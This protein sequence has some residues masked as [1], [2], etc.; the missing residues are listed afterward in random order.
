MPAPFKIISRKLNVIAAAVN[1]AGAFLVFLYFQIID[2][3]P[4]GQQAVR[5]PDIGS[6][7]FFALVMAG[8]FTL[9]GFLVDKNF[10][11][12]EEWYTRLRE[13][14]SPAESPSEIQR[15]V[16]NYS[17]T[18]AFMTFLMWN[19]AGIT[20][21]ILNLFSGEGSAAYAIRFFGG[22]VGVG[23][24]LTTPIHYFIIDQVWRD[25]IAV[26]FPQGELS[27]IKS[28]R[29]PVLGRLLIVFL[30]IGLWPLGLMA[31]LS[32][33]R[34]QLLVTSA[35][36]QAILDNLLILQLFLIVTGLLASVGLAVFVTQSIVRPLREMQNAMSRVEQND[37]NTQVSVTSNDELGYLGERFNQMT[38]GLRQGELL[39]NLLNLYVSPEV[40]RQAIEQGTQLGGTLVECT[41]LFSDIRSFTTLSENLPPAELIGLLNR[42][43]SAMVEVIIEQGGMVNKFGGDSLLAVFGTPLNPAQDHAARAVRT[44]MNMRGSLA[45]FNEEQ[46]KIKAPLI[47]IGIGVATGQVVAGN[48]GG[49]GRI[50]YTVIGDTVNLASRLQDKTKELDHEILISTETYHAASSLLSLNTQLI[51]SITVKGKN[52]PL[53]VYAVT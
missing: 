10:K 21:L 41:V 40:A 47:R 32:F 3:Q 15:S 33:Q 2:P 30:L 49:Q 51:S 48:V 44:A 6:I 8:L 5:A 29:L 37:F 38:A 18:S 1:L 50:E 45:R 26:F 36:P 52:L 11:R 39:R 20:Y 23:G 34:A 4:V 27:R 14:A 22:L 13:G 12:I 19:L 53:D 24:M 7:I 42:Y 46:T 17:L 25:V 43:M 9:S 28:F 35:Y 31:S 16:L